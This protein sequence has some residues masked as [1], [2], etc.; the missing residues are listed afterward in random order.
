MEHTHPVSQFRYRA[1]ISYSH[2]D[3]AWATW[4]HKALETWRVPSRLVGTITAHG[5]IPRRLH[6]IFRDRDELAS[7]TDLGRTVN[8]ALAQSENLIVICSPASAASRWVNE[9][10]LAFK[11]L[12]RGGR[13]F[14]LI[15]DGEPNATDL[16]GRAAEESFC[17]ALRFALDANGQPSVARTEPIAAD[18]R[19]GKDG[20]ANAKLKLIAGMLDVGFDALKQREQHRQLRRLAIVA[21]LAV[22]IMAVTAVL[23][24]FAVIAR[25]DAERR[26]KQAED[27]VGFM[28]GDLNDKLSEVQRLDIMQA[29]DDKAM[30][31][32]QSLPATDV[33]DLAVVQRAKALEKIGV[34]RQESGNL[35]GALDAFAASAKLSAGLA[36]ARRNDVARQ[37]AYSRTLAYIGMVHWNQSDLPAAQDVFEAARRALRPSLAQAPDDPA[38]LEQLVFLDNDIGHVVEARGDVDAALGIFRERLDL[39]NK[40]VAAAPHDDKYATAPG[41]AHNDLGRL[42]L[43]Q[44]DLA[45]AIAEYRADNLIESRVSAQNPRDNAQRQEAMRVDAILGRTLALAGDTGNGTLCLQRAVDVAAELVKVDPNNTDPQEL[46]ALYDA[47]LARLRRLDGEASAAT[48]LSA[49]SVAIFTDLNRKDPSNAGWQREFAE[50]RIEQASESLAAGHADAARTQAGAAVTALEA[51]LA[52]QPQNSATVLATTSAKLLLAQTSSD[53]QVAAGLRDAALNTLATQKSGRDD[54][55]L[56]ALQ[57]NALLGLGK[58]AEAKPL[59]DRLWKSGYRDPALL[60]T[61]RREHIDYPANLDFAQRLASIMQPAAD[62]PK[63]SRPIRAPPSTASESTTPQSKDGH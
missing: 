57:V 30:A 43:Q 19:P 63:S 17:P 32:F 13:I 5:T 22:A 50:A 35:P 47:Q 48:A 46:L 1:F 56:L 55:R 25:H 21:A 60:M 18:A 12:G 11:R 51:L 23:A 26:Q 45:T 38:L 27:L 62:T 36:N 44:G 15:V 61:L 58:I 53:P 28:L 3:D 29:V 2:S 7:A 54:P 52:R 8:A 59:L 42:A 16:P 40:L 34:V 49:Q 9:E 33:N 41:D 6:P 24:T 20:R 31:Y 37:V 4:L 10:V 39:A 14:C